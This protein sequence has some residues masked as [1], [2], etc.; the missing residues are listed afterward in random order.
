MKK[1]LINLYLEFLNDFLTI[2]KFAEYCEMNE[3]DT[4][5]LL[6]IGA[7]LNKEEVKR[8]KEHKHYEKIRQFSNHNILYIQGLKNK[9]RTNTI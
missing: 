8:I 3:K 4:E 7:K 6:R 1:Q 9:I 2:E 5:E